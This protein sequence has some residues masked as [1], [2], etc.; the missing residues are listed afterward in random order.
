MGTGCIWCKRTV[1]SSEAEVLLEC[2]FARCVSLE[3][4]SA[5]GQWRRLRLHGVGFSEFLGFE[6]RVVWEYC[7]KSIMFVNLMK[8]SS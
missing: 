7:S 5:W 4:V 3:M 1:S 6:L 8:K 2:A